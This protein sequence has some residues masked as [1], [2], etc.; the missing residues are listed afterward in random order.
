M[1]NIDV[2]LFFHI[3]IILSESSPFSF[4]PVAI[5]NDANHALNHKRTRE[6]M[7]GDDVSGDCKRPYLEKDSA[8]DEVLSDISDDADE[9]LNRED[10]VS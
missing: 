2:F 6:I 10:S 4:F 9:I 7:D 8:L 1:F 5:E 3:N